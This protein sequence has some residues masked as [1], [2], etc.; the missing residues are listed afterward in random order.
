[1]NRHFDEFSKS[2]AESCSRRE[3]LRAVGA[4]FAGA[5]LS[6]VPLSSVWA[7]GPDPCKAFCKCR[8][9]AQQN[10]C[11]SACRACGGDTSRLC[12]SCGN[13]VCCSAG[14][15][16]CSGYCVDRFND[17]LNCGACGYVCLPGPNEVADCL[18]GQCA[19]TCFE[20]A[21]RCN[22]NCTFLNSDPRN[23]GVCG[24]A[25]PASAPLCDQGVCI[26]NNCNFPFIP[27]GG[28][29][30]DPTSDRNNCGGCGVKCADNEAC[31]VGFCESG[32]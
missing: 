23:C 28:A 13:Y 1:M 5:V 3:S 24:N 27:C 21:V 12:G 29:C 10:Q 7:K 26:A 25:C 4:L 19:Y 9:K 18:D 15:G 17:P 6:R 2:L 22:G 8:N 32:G 20:G 30:V 16:C 31:I 14:Y 11:L